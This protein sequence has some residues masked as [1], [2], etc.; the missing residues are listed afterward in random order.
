MHRRLQFEAGLQAIFLALL[1]ITATNE[2]IR[3]AHKSMDTVARVSKWQTLR[4]Y[5]ILSVMNRLTP[6]ERASFVT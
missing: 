6:S 4:R 1:V 5:Y 2:H 3:S